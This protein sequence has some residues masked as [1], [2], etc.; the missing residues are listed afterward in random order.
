MSLEA[1][2]VEISVGDL[3]LIVEDARRKTDDVETGGN[4]SLS[5]KSS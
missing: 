1:G 3:D 4:P 5:A 2:A